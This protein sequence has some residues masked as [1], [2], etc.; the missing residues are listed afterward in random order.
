MWRSPSPSLGR[1]PPHWLGRCPPAAVLG[2]GPLFRGRRLGLVDIPAVDLG[3][4]LLPQCIFPVVT[5]GPAP[6]W[7]LGEGWASQAGFRGH[8][9]WADNWSRGCKEQE[10]LSSMWPIIGAVPRCSTR[11]QML[12]SNPRLE[13]QSRLSLAPAPW[14]PQAR[15]CGNQGGACPPSQEAPWPRQSS[16]ET[17]TEMGPGPSGQHEKSPTP[18]VLAVD[19][20]FHGNREGSAGKGGCGAGGSVSTGTVR[21]T[22]Q[23]DPEATGGWHGTWILQLESRYFHL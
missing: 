4:S 8:V 12:P 18:P 1:G 22:V 10:D 9:R 14:D 19:A 3:Y 11:A 7:G 15:C 17:E 6:A 21:C 20:G 5:G 16:L 13:P 23:S 2:T